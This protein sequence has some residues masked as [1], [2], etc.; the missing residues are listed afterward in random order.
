MLKKAHTNRWLNRLSVW[1]PLLSV[2]AI[3][4]FVFVGS[5]AL[6]SNTAEITQWL[7]DG[8][9][10]RQQYDQFVEQFGGDDF[11]FVT[12]PGCTLADKR[13]ARLSE[14]LTTRVKFDGGNGDVALIRRVITGDETLKRLTS[15]PLKLSRAEALRR[16]RGIFVGVDGSTTGALVLLTDEGQKHK[17]ELIEQIYQ[18]AQAECGVDRQSLRLG[19]SVYEAVVIDQESVRS[20]RG[21]TLPIFAATLLLTWWCFRSIRLVVIVLAVGELCRSGSLAMVYFTGGHINAVLVVLP[22]LVFVTTISGAV[23]LVNYYHEIVRE[24]GQQGAAWRAVRSGFLPC[25]LASGTT[26]IGLASLYVTQIEPVRSFG[27]YGAVGILISLVVLLAV[28]PGALEASS[29]RV[30]PQSEHLTKGQLIRK[31]SFGAVIARK[32]VRHRRWLAV[33]A[34][35]VVVL[36]SIGLVWTKTTVKL[37]RMFRPESTMVRNY[38]WIEEHIGP[39][40]PIEILVTFNKDCNLDMLERLE[41]VGHLHHAIGEDEDVGS[42]MSAVTLTPPIPNA[43]GARGVMR[44]TA[45]AKQL[46]QEKHCLVEEG[47]LAEGNAGQVWRITARVPAM[48]DLDYGDFVSRVRDRAESVVR[49]QS[50]VRAGDVSLAYTGIAPM[51]HHAQGQLLADLTNSFTTAAVQIAPTMILILRSPVAGMLAMIPNIAPVLIVFGV[52]GWL[53]IPVDIGSILTA[54]IAVG[55]AVDDTL[56]VL[57]W[58]T[59]GIRA[60][61]HPVRAIYRAY[62][63]CGKSMIQTS[64]I[65]GLGLLVLVHSSYVPASQFGWL[66]FVILMAAVACDFVMLPLILASPLGKFFARSPQRVPAKRRLLPFRK[67]PD[68]SP[69]MPSFASAEAA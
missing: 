52:L 20:L 8:Q 54:S 32:V 58:Y 12:W 1:L 65:C 53:G 28:V 9:L 25:V 57:T 26:A 23:H 3:A 69:A 68:Y 29:R 21:Y 40:V 42:T 47:F 24:H 41:L 37:E 67:R 11:L 17:K 34:A 62:D 60:G 33:A 64:L 50:S 5:A 38:R 61:Q 45:F 36:S 51:V 39:M 22:V 16:M 31:K 44:R 30:S 2:A 49:E 13:L 66:M 19:G 48:H 35:A 15:H 59:R 18:V 14:A 4:P 55:I 63:H 7:P 46:E 27:I 6:E 10:E 43:R 56:H